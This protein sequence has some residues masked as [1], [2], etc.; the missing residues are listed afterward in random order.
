MQ[1]YKDS[2]F[3]IFQPDLRGA[4][5][6]FFENRNVRITRQLAAEFVDAAILDKLLAL[7]FIDFEADSGEYHLDDR[8]ERFFDEMFGA[9][10]VAQADWL[11]GLL[12]ELRRL[13]EGHQTVDARK[14][15][16]FLRR[17]C[18]LMRTCMNRVQRHL[19]DIKAAVDYDYRAGS[20][21]E[22]KLMKLQWHLDRSRSYGGAVADLNSLLR[23][24]TFFQIHQEIELLSLRGRLI[25]TCSRVGDALI[26]VYQRIE[27]YLNRVLRDYSRARKL[28]RLRGLI[29]RHE[30]LASTNLCDVAA[31]TNGPWFREFRVRT[32]L[33]AR[34]I[35]AR[36]ELV[37]RALARIGL[38]ICGKTRCVELARHEADELPPIIDWSN[39]FDA[40]TKQEQDLF[41]FLGKVRVEGRNLTEEERIDGYCA[42]LCNQD[43][44]TT[45]DHRSFP[46]AFGQE[47]E[48][49]VIKPPHENYEY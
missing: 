34:V 6:R 8:V 14:G 45:L 21:Y 22:I 35:D 40:F 30:H 42:I 18:R 3:R 39:V 24:D 37:T 4:L 33:D 29:E 46:I 23:N 36:P 15:E 2:F 47:W 43:W 48:Y 11:I 5:Q 10:E 28:I 38:G 41:A 26:D 49:A 19:E 17:I 13:I 9:A 32:L 44:I 16:V 20:D 1:V 25:Q 31:A 12:E 27:D 7:E